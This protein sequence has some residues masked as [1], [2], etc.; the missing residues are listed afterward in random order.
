[1]AAAG[2]K[3]SN[4]HH[5]KFVSFPCSDVLISLAVLMHVTSLVV[6]KCVFVGILTFF[7]LLF[8][9]NYFIYFNTHSFNIVF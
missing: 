1:M 3:S 9:E 5:T 6:K 4:P 2:L 7:Q 8:S